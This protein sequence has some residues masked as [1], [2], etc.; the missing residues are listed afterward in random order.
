MDT[1]TQRQVFA[2]DINP[3]TAMMLVE[4][5]HQQYKTWNP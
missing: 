2:C 5:D 4:N 1:N 3:F